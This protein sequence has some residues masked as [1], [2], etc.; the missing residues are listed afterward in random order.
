VDGE[1]EWLALRNER[2]IWQHRNKRSFNTLV[3]VSLSCL[4]LDVCQK[5]QYV[6]GE[7]E[8]LAQRAWH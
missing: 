3:P 1:Q 6:D 5:V 2:V 4:F 8:W 7:Q